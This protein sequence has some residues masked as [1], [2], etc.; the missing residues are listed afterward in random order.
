MLNTFDPSSLNNSY[1]LR[2]EQQALIA[3]LRKQPLLIVLRPSKED[4]D[5]LLPKNRPIIQTIEKLNDLG[6]K[7]IE[8]AW[9]SHPAWAELIEELRQNF[10]NIS[11]GAASITNI[12]GLEEVA[13]LGL[14]YAMSPYLDPPLLLHARKLKQLLIPGVFSPTEIHEAHQSGCE[15]VKVFPASNIGI[16]YIKQLQ[17]PYPSL[18]FIIAAGGL[19]AADLK[20]WLENG[21]DALTLGRKLIEDDQID[22][23]LQAWLRAG[24]SKS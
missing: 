15:L 12:E 10:T 17:I 5:Q 22:P 20:P 1:S 23:D 14:T 13:R 19:R 11:L 3:A 24:L 6:V 16:N 9:A 8:I 7:H 21:Y 4:L 18:P 2:N